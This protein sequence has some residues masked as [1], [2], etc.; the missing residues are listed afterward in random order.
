MTSKYKACICT[1]EEL[2]PEAIKAGCIY[3][4]TDTD[5]V[6]IAP[7]DGELRLVANFDSAELVQGFV[8]EIEKTLLKTND[9]IDKADANLEKLS[10]E[11]S[12]K[13]GYAEVK[14]GKLSLYNRIKGKLL[15]GPF[16]LGGTK[17]ETKVVETVKESVPFAM[18]TGTA[19]TNG[20]G[21]MYVYFKGELGNGY[22]VF[23]QADGKVAVTKKEALFFT[24]SGDPDTPFSWLAV[25]G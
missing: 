23:L 25:R 18:E 11:V 7:A 12:Q 9:R 2:Q 17:T 10:K 6:F 22:N 20:D 3:L 4:A 5:E 24:V 8:Q 13:I 21:L 15:S 16:D 1:K 14:N 19:T